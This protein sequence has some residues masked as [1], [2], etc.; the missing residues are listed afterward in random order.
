MMMIDL[1]QPLTPPQNEIMEI[2][3]LDN[4]NEGGAIEVVDTEN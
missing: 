2:E 1:P 3:K 4:K